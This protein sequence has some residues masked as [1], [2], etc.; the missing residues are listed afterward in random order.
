M[1]TTTSLE[2][3]LRQRIAELETEN[4]ELRSDLEDVRK[5]RRELRDIVCST[6]P[7]APETSDEEYEEMLKNHVPG[8]GRR[9]LEGLG[10][11]P[12]AGS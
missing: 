7:P 12:R 10:I 3:Q 2:V 11:L 5:E 1:T 9:F 6:V 4:A 8:S